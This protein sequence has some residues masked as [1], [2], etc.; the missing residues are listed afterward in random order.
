MKNSKII[1]KII[2]KIMKCIILIILIIL[3]YFINKENIPQIYNESSYFTS[4]ATGIYPTKSP[5]IELHDNSLRQ[6]IRVSAG[7]EKIRIKFSNL[8]GES[9]LEIKKV[10]IADLISDTEINVK[11]SKFLKFNGKN[12]IIIEPE[13]EIYS[14]TISYP[15]KTFSNIAITVYLGKIP[16][17]LSGHS[18]SYT[19]SY[20]E[21]GNKINKRKFSER[22]KIDHWYFI[23]AL[24]ISSD[25]PKKV[26]VCFGDSITD[27]VKWNGNYRDNYPAILFSKL[28]IEN[29][30]TDISVVNQG[31]NADMMFVRGLKRYE[32]DVLD[33]KGI[34]YIIVLMGVNDINVINST[35]EKVISGYK[36]LIKKAHEKNILIY[37]AT[38]MPFSTYKCKYLW[39]LVKE[40]HRNNANKW[41]R[42]TKPQNGGFDAFF[43]FDKFVRDPL[44]ATSLGPFA[45][46]GDGIHPGTG[47]YEKMVES[48]N[49]LS[50]FSKNLDICYKCQGKFIED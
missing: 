19:Y 40:K 6:I 9:P 50:L 49:D 41:I 3:L 45:D 7:G 30:I 46:S 8:I 18:Y 33:I 26:I 23:S 4:W 14:D 10:C 11:T 39:N 48:I 37:G 32:H 22:N 28:Y 34:K 24:E 25:N 29:K 21:K 13:N 15:L 1:G 20:V 35:S 5:K 38:I 12:N 44:N 47:G 43:D 42:N 16:N 2:G 36:Q 27:G 17:E 31:I